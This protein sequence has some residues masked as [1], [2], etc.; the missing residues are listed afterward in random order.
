M[1]GALKDYGVAKI[2]GET[3]FGKGTVQEINYFG[4]GSSVKLTVAKWL[5]PLGHSIQKNGVAPDIEVASG[6]NGSDPQLERALVEIA[7][8]IR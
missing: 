8:L 7:K 6:T 2:I 4:D 5:T 1:A 3:T